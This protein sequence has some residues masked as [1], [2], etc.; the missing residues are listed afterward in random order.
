[1]TSKHRFTDRILKV[2]FVE[3][4]DLKYNSCSIHI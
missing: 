1:M 2:L 4:F 3:I